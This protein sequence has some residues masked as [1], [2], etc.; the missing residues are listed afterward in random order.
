MS[1]RD[2]APTYGWVATSSLNRWLARIFVAVILISFIAAWSIKY[3]LDRDCTN[4]YKRELKVLGYWVD[5]RAGS[6][7]KGCP[8]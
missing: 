4:L 2:S 7:D 1:K 3:S 8:Q 5:V 6:N